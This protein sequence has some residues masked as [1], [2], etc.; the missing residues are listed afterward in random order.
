[1]SDLNDL[2]HTNAQRAFELGA[3]RER[4]RIVR[5][6]LD[7][8]ATWRKPTSFSYPAELTKLIDLIKGEQ[9]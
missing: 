1:M 4:E 6:L 2:I 3:M 5:L 8:K 7:V 9:K